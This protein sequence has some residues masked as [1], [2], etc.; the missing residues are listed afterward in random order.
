MTIGAVASV[1]GGLVSVG[2]ALF[3]PKPGFSQQGNALNFQTNPQSGLPYAIGRTRMSGLRIHVS[4]WDYDGGYKPLTP[5][6]AGGGFGG[7]DG[8]VDPLI[9]DSALI[10]VP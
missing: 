8:A 4:T 7:G 10:A 3:Q 5:D 6:S 1:A 2:T 9:M